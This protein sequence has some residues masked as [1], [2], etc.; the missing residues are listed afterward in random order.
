M[1][2]RYLINFDL[3]Q[4]KKIFTDFLIVGSGIAGLYTSLKIFDKGE[5]TLLT[6]S[7]LKESNT[8]YAQGGIAVALGDKDSPHLHME[9]TLKAG[10]N[11]CDPEAVNILVTEGPKCVEELIELGTKFDKIEGKYNTTLEAAHQRP[12]ILHARGDA[13]GAEI[14]ESLSQKVINENKIKIKENILV[15]DILTEHNTCYGV[16]VLH[17][18]TNEI[19]AY[20]AKAI[21]LASGGA[22]QLFLNTTN[23]EVATGDGIA[24][25]YRGGA[26]VTDL[27]F[28][29]FHP[30]ALYHQGSPKFLI[31]EA[32]RGEGAIL[33]NIK[34]EL[35]MPSYHPLAELA[36][37]DIVARA[38]TDQMKKT[39]SN[40]VYL[41]ASKIKD[42]FSQRFPTIYKNCISLGI[43]PEKEYI[44]VAPAAH[45]TMGGIKT[46]TWG[47]TNLTNLYA[48]G[49][50]TSTGVH[51]ANRL[52]SNSLLEGLVFGNRIAQKVKEN[53]ELFSQKID[54]EKNIFYNFP[55]KEIR[56]FDSRQITKELQKLM[57]DK[58]G[59]IRNSSDLKQA[60]QKINEWKFIL[61]SELRTTEDFEL[62]NLIILADLITK[63]ALQREESRGAHYR[64]D[65]PDRDDINWKKH[66]IY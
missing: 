64:K 38:I 49:E 66:I 56:K 32:V 60:I 39:N 27:E 58:V 37:R 40:Y 46:D 52:A 63:S 15:I 16:L 24:F 36:P 25:A 10:A 42:K 29:Q 43:N 33:K 55:R 14:E 26:K 48:C 2:P 19:I 35:F 47:Q 8:E 18:A 34:G 5:V 12:R 50:C 1:F 30:T 41:D 57:W 17:S 31:S 45:Y 6:K 53:K 22:G 51:G 23:P 61:K 7:K 13:T 28:I 44:P 20:L 3:S 4:V 59:I 62:A 21:I 54:E 65:F 11:F 9:D